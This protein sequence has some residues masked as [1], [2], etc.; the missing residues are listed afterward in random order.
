[1]VLSCAL[2]RTS[3]L[4]RQ[5]S[6]GRI[7]EGLALPHIMD[8]LLEGAL[9]TLAHPRGCSLADAAT[10][11]ACSLCLGGASAAAPGG[12]RGPLCS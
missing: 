2:R 6:R 8:A 10:L 4:S 9:R 3:P 11:P 12:R 1:M 5:S 7:L